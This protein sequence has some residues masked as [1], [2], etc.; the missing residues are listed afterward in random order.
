M[1]TETTLPCLR[2]FAG[3]VAIVTGGTSGIGR[4][5]TQRLAD[6]GA[7][8]VAVHLNANRGAEAIEQFGDA[9]HVEV[10]DVTHEQAFTNVVNRSVERFG[11]LHILVNCAGGARPGSLLDISQEDWEV[12]F[13]I[14]VNAQLFGIRLAA[15]HFI[16]RKYAGAVV[17]ISSLAGISPSHLSSY[18]VSKAAGIM[19]TRQA[20]LELSQY[21][22]RVNAIS[23]GLVDTEA[24]QARFLGNPGVLEKYCKRIPFGRPARVEEIAGVVAFL[25][26]EDASYI[27]GENVVVDGAWTQ[28]LY[29]DL[30]HSS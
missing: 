7:T 28:S 27:T 19:L 10:A 8:V 5:I 16:E 21:G 13:R 12:A 24:V 6:E 15:R 11:A 1:S 17:N 29:P 14:N 3:H 23:P 26:S 20:A 9:V 4:A 30:T 22:I 2:R 18:S 25:A